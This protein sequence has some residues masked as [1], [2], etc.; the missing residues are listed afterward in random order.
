MR[1]AALAQEEPHA[2]IAVK[3]RLAAANIFWRFLAAIF[4]GS[5]REATE[6]LPVGLA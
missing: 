1:L 4:S 5:A 3:N 2:K 6:L